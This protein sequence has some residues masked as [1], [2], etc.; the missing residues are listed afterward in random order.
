MIGLKIFIDLMV[1]FVLYLI[2]VV[3]G[4]TDMLEEDPLLFFS[5]IIVDGFLIACGIIPWI[6]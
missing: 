6:V 3:V 2:N 1:L 4:P 5:A